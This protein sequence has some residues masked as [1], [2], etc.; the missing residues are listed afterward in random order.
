[1]GHI[2]ISHATVGDERVA[3]L[4]RALEGLGCLPATQTFLCRTSV[5]EFLWLSAAVRF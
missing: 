3:D 2:F 4:R 5:L 1:M